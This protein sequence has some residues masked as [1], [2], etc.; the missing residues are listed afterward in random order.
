MYLGSD[1]VTTDGSGDANITT[2]LAVAVAAGD[3]ITA[4]ATDPSNNTS[5]F[6]NAVVVTASAATL[7]GRYCFNEDT[8]GQGPVQVLDDQ[9]SPVHMDITYDAPVTSWTE[10]GGNRGLNASAPGHTGLLS[11]P[12]EELNSLR[13]K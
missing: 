8:S 9:A 4:T 1:T 12:A 7:L 11:G 10:V 13:L 3:V 2:V 5:E 6:S